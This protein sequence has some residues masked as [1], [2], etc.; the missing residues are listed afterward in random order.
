[1]SVR[2]ALTGR[3]LACVVGLALASVTARS[4]GLASRASESAGPAARADS[5]ARLSLEQVERAALDSNPGLRVALLDVAAVRR[6]V[7][8]AGLRPNPW[9]VVTGDVFGP[10][11]VALQPSANQWGLS[12]Q[13][14]LELGAK[15]QRRS[16]VAEAVYSTSRLLLADSARRVLLV[17]RLAFYDVQA[18]DQGLILAQRNVDLYARLVALDQSRLEQKQISGAE[19]S[20]AVL[21]RAQS[22]LARDLAELQLLKAQDALGLALGQRR[23]LAARDTL[24]T[25]ARAPAP[26]AALEAQALRERPDV[27]AGRAL[28]RSAGANVRLQEANGVISPTVGV[29]FVS[30]QGQPSYGVSGTV[31]LALFNRNQGERSKAVVRQDQ[32]DRTMRAVE[33]LALTDVRSAWSEFETRRVALSRFT[34]GGAEGILARAQAVLESTQYAYRAGGVSL[35]E[36]LDAVRTF[37]DITRAYVDA[38]TAY[39]KSVA[40]LDAA[41]GADTARLLPLASVDAP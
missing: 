2:R 22:D 9:L 21:A 5:T 28:R 13:V 31:P 37:A 23:R 20:R 17:V 35:L 40:T 14:P 27:L 11:G 7:V 34:T 10:G 3:A 39:N 36:F 29:D 32:A 18:A 15:R 38:V 6:D 4:Q 41:S 19:L 25:I 8:T 24:A 1:M 12:L 26:L 30:Q 33:L 16:D